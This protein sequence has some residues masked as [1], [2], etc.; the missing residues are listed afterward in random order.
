MV[1][2]K[3]KCWIN[4]ISSIKLTV[5]HPIQLNRIEVVQWLRSDKTMPDAIIVTNILVVCSGAS[6]NH[7]C[8]RLF[9]LAMSISNRMIRLCSADGIL[10]AL[11]PMTTLTVAVNRAE[12]HRIQLNVSC[13]RKK[14][15][16]VRKNRE[17]QK[18]K[19]RA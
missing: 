6:E 12:V 5:I 4:A 3:K 9:E 8:S 18:S 17:T 11:S 2:A 19:Q 10:D 15:V 14:C 1:I 7:K 13:R 16:S